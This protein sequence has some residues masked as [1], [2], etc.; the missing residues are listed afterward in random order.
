MYLYNIKA[1]IKVFYYKLNLNCK[2]NLSYSF[3]IPFIFKTLG[4]DIPKDAEPIITYSFNMLILSLIILACFINITGYFISI[5]LIKKYNIEDKYPK[6]SKL[7]RYFE[8]SNIF[9]VII[10]I[11]LCLFCLMIIII[12]NLG[13]LGMF[14]FVK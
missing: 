14:I 1:K 10:E 9:F 8:K 6:Y 13:I 2:T 4:S 7:I 11:I 3:I 5:Y 12:L